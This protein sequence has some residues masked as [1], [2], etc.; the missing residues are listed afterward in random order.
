[1]LVREDKTRT[2]AVHDGNVLGHDGEAERKKVGWRIGEPLVAL[3]LLA[4][5]SVTA[6]AGV[7][8]EPRVGPSR[9]SVLPS[10]QMVQWY[11]AY[12]NR[13]PGM[14]AQAS[15]NG[16][17]DF[18]EWSE[19]KA[20]VEQKLLPQAK[21]FPPG[22]TVT[23]DP[24]GQN[25]IVVAPDGGA[26]GVVLMQDVAEDRRTLEDGFLYL[27]DDTQEHVWYKF[28]RYSDGSY[29]QAPLALALH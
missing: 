27:S 12:K 19:F 3:M 4:L 25:V 24:A 13:G 23:L 14:C 20:E 29:L 7:A 9:A 6:L 15:Q 26:V 17:A 21:N 5:V 18:L 2:A 22:S 1:M 28:Q 16:C 11:P 10:P 8:A